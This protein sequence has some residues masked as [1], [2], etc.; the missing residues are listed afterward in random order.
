MIILTE[1]KYNIMA[2]HLIFDLQGTPHLATETESGFLTQSGV[3]ANSNIRFACPV[4]ELE[5]RVRRV[6]KGDS[7]WVRIKNK[8]GFA[9][10]AYPD[11]YR[12]NAILEPNA[13]DSII[14]LSEARRL[15]LIQPKP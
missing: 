2:T 13:T 11:V 7:V 9:L 3:F 8:Y 15:G 12:K 6:C 10:M 4:A 14:H 1:K 5:K